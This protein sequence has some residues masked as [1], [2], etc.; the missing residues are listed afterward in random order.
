MTINCTKQPWKSGPVLVM[1]DSW[2]LGPTANIPLATVNNMLTLNGTYP[3]RALPPGYVQANLGTGLTT[4][5]IANDVIYPPSSPPTS[6]GPPPWTGP[7]SCHPASP[8]PNTNPANGP[9][10]AL[11]TS[12]VNT[13]DMLQWLTEYIG[14]GGTFPGCAG[15]IMSIGA[16]DMG[17]WPVPPVS[18]SLA[19]E[20]GYSTAP[21]NVISSAQST[22]NLIGIGSACATLGLRCVIIGMPTFFAYQGPPY[23]SPS[24]HALGIATGSGVD[25]RYTNAADQCPNLQLIPGVMNQILAQMPDWSYVE[26]SVWQTP[27]APGWEDPFFSQAVPHPNVAG[28]N[29]LASAVWELHT[30]LP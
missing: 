12:D 27:A 22:T 10:N 19:T 24:G 3:K 17:D 4:L 6:F 28:F 21:S 9:Y 26:G 2:A 15:I 29:A 14:Q 13:C 1:G 23:P 20:L 7:G 16:H 8:F 5:G 18:W 11:L 30:N 25:A